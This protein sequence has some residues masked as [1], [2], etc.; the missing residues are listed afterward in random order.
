MLLPRKPTDI[1]IEQIT[2]PSG[3][4]KI[5]CIIMRPQEQK[6]MLP[7][8]LWIHGGGYFAGMKEMVY[9]SRAVSLV[10]D[11]GAVVLCPGYRLAFYKPYPAAVTDCYQTLLCIKE[12]AQTLG[13]R[14]HQIFVGGESAGG[15]LAVAVCMMAR[16]QGT[17]NIAYQM[18]LYPMLDCL[19][20]DSS[21]DNHGRVWNT[22]KNHFGWHIY[23]RNM[24]KQHISPYASPARQTDYS[25]LPPAYTFVGDGEPFYDETR[26]YIENLQKCGIHAQID[27]YHSDMHAFDMMKPDWEISRLAAKHFNEHYVYAVEHYFAEQVSSR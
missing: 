25:H 4:R 15:G 14:D 10:R 1:K 7:G 6:E 24:D 13:I 3:N 8:I 23:L 16:D 17:V 27:I 5:P 19:D 2:I 18:P 26:T 11:Y 12:Q 21:R 20:T 22:W 9:M